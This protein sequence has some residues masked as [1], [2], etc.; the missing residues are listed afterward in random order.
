L[1]PPLYL[2]LAINPPNGASAVVCASDPQAAARFVWFGFG[3]RC[4]VY[5][6]GQ[7]APGVT[8]GRVGYLQTPPTGLVL[9]L[10]ASDLRAAM[11]AAPAGQ[12]PGGGT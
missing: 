8:A 6:L 1:S 5:C 2:Y 3:R 7:A 11:A 9:T 4:D 10:T 12:G